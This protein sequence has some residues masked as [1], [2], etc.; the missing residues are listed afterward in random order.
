MD[1]F[2]EIKNFFSKGDPIRNAIFLKEDH[3]YENHIANLHAIYDQV[4][5]EKKEWIDRDLQL[6]TYG[7]FGEDS[8][9][10][11]LK[12]S[13]IPMIVLHGLTICYG[14]LKAQIDYLII[15]RKFNLVLE[16]KNLFGNIQID[17]NG[18]FIRT[19]DYKGFR[20]K[21][22]IYSPIT[23]LERHMDILKNIRKDTRNNLLTRSLFEIGFKNNYKSLV[24]LANPKTVINTRYAKKEIKN[25]IIRCDGLNQSIHQL[26]KDS[27]D[28]PNKSDE[29]MY[30]LA[31]M[32][33]DLHINDDKDYAAKYI[34]SFD[35]STPSIAVS[36]Q[37]TVTESSST[38]N[39]TFEETPI[40]TELKRYRLQKSRDEKIKPYFIYNNAQMEELI[41]HM[42]SSK[43]DLIKIRGF[44]STKYDL[45]GEDI[46]SIIE[47]YRN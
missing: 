14:D 4:S 35:T 15:T 38:S 29:E 21:E 6:L 5:S 3:S 8:V 19:I 37:D 16:C 44:G 11:E 1:L 7:K 18:N 46:L 13:F 32:F 23:Q 30:E 36:Q 25:K 43:E 45:Y 10:Y 31:K 28:N 47:K 22:G 12:N 40:Y 2:C 17:S 26:L 33:L 42:P 41:K 39:L 27:K 20:K 9:A 34:S 24:V